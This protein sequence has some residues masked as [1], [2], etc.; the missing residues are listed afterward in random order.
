LR[1]VPFTLFSRGL[2]HLLTKLRSRSEER[3]YVSQSDFEQNLREFLERSEA[4]GVD[5]VVVKI[6]TAGDKY[7]SKNPEA[8]AAIGKYNDIIDDVTSTI[9]SA[10]AIRPLADSESGEREIVDDHTLEEGYH[11]NTDGH[12]LLYKRI[13]DAL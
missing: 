11:L 9:P 8:Q 12:A 4:I 7:E 1:A 6:L 3:A 10:V 13:S 2:S 5:T